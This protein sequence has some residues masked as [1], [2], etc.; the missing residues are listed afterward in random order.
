[1]NGDD[2][3]TA[4]ADDQADRDQRHAQAS[5]SVCRRS[6]PVE[7]R[8]RRRIAIAPAISVPRMPSQSGTQIHSSERRMADV[9]PSGWGRPRRASRRAR[10]RAARRQMNAT[11]TEQLRRRHPAPAA[12]Q[13]PPVREDER[14]RDR[15]QRTAGP[16]RAPELQRPAVVGDE[17]LG[18]RR[19]ERADQQ[20]PGDHVARLT[21][22]DQQPDEAGASAA[23]ATNGAIHLLRTAREV[24]LGSQDDHDL[25]A[26]GRERQG[27]GEDA[28]QPFHREHLSLFAALSQSVPA[29]R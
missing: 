11:K 10:C 7:R 3:A 15:P 22:R 17:K 24:R 16:D 29:P 9:R 21:D 1:M 23:S 6:T 13:Q 26:R 14:D 19:E 5:Q 12:S 27:A 25:H 18:A 8:S 20:D 28:Q 2:P 4:E